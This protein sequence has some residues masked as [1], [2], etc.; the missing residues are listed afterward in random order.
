MSAKSASLQVRRLRL[1]TATPEV[2]RPYGA[3]LGP[4]A[5]IAPMPVDYYSGAVAMSR[6][7]AFECSSRVEVSLTSLRQRPL[8]VHYLER[9]FQHTQTFIPLNGKPFIAVLAPPSEGEMPDLDQVRAFRFDGTAGLCLDIGTWHEFP[10]P[11]DDDTHIVVLLSSQVTEDLQQRAANGIE[12]FGPDLDK[13]D[14]TL[15]AG[16][17]YEVIIDPA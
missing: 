16:V 17:R 10:F 4:R 8:E 9:H 1:V 6:P 11:L 2:I 15:R 3:W 7:V 12:A 13:K 5:D 14:M